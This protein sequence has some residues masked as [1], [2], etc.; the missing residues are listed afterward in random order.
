MVQF[1]GAGG[2]EGP[3]TVLGEKGA[4]LVVYGGG[5]GEGGG[6]GLVAGGWISEVRE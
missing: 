1:Y 4:D 6:G 3:S 2:G 5:A